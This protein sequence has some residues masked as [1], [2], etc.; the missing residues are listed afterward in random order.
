MNISDH[1]AV[2][3]FLNQ[4]NKQKI[5]YC[6]FKSNEH[7]NAGIQ[8][9]TD[10]DVLIDKGS[11]KEVCLALVN[12]NFKLFRSTPLSGYPS[13]ED[14]IGFDVTTGNLAHIHLH[15][16]LVLGES[17]LKGYRIPWEKTILNSR[18]WDKNA[19][20]YVSSPEME[21]LLLLTRSALKF[22]FRS[23]IRRALFGIPL[24]GEDIDREYKWLLKRIDYKL[25]ESV[26]S[27]VL[28]SNIINL[29]TRELKNKKVRSQE[30]HIFRL[31]IKRHLKPW[32]TFNLFHAH[33]ERW[34]RE[35][36]LKVRNKLLNRMGYMTVDRRSPS[37]GGIVV[38]VLGSDGSGKSTQVKALSTWLDWKID[39]VSVY[40]GSGDGSISWHRSILR[41]IQ[42]LVG[43]LI[44]KKTTNT[45][46]NYID[47][48][49]GLGGKRS[50]FGKL[51][52]SVYAISLAIEKRSTVK[53]VIRARNKGM[54][55]LCDRYPQNQIKG[56]NDGP[57]LQDPSDSHK[58]WGIF[59]LV[60][61]KVLAVFSRVEPDLVI[62]LNVSECIAKDRKPDTPEEMIK[63]KIDAVRRLKFSSECKIVL[64]DS[65]LKFED[66]QITMRKVLWDSV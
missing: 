48:H 1:L 60:E 32:K 8:G 10:L 52:Y 17:N 5:I 22:R 63:K 44:V 15:W 9:V 45:S 36:K 18:I 41:F 29:V 30:M 13:V 16:Q 2:R 25:F 27:I 53:K 35:Y 42:R 59:A 4:I 6:H 55:V 34:S 11:Y 61:Q 65:N 54:I 50:F 12:A 19:Q 3:F 62:K 39:V 38:A 40:F 56:Y 58:L 64:V 51:F 24:W 66:V 43:S 47:R 21:L 26:F 31:Q 57:L 37:T 46:V 33:I 7:V 28:P 23:L 14:W 20:I 49:R